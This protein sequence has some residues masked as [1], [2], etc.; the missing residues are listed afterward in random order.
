M[1]R[2]F[3]WNHFAL[4]LGDRN[5]DFACGDSVKNIVDVLF[6]HILD[7]NVILFKLFQEEAGGLIDQLIG[8]IDFVLCKLFL[9]G[10]G[11]GF[12]LFLVGVALD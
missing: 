12:N 10:G 5:G 1:R 4:R 3:V 7:R 11:Q 2:F 8:K 9:D 6:G